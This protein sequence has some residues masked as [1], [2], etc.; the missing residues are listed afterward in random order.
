VNA[1]IVRQESNTSELAGATIDPLNDTCSPIKEQ[2]K[3]QRRLKE[4]AAFRDN[5]EARKLKV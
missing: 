1:R 3:R 5:R 2:E 4:P